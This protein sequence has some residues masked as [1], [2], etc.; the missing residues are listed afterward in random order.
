MKKG[1]LVLHLPSGTTLVG[2][3]TRVARDGSWIDVWWGGRYEKCQ[4]IG[5]WPKRMRNQPLEV[6]S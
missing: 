1:D 3:V 5:G 6:I 2:V 4:R